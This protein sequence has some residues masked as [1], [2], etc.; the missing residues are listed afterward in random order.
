MKGINCDV[1]VDE[2]GGKYILSTCWIFF[3]ISVFN[4]TLNNG[5]KV[6][7]KDFSQRSTK[8]IY[9]S[10]KL[11]LPFILKEEI[12]KKITLKDMNRYAGRNTSLNAAF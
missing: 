9:R 11:P 5:K 12:S 3:S 4:R 1:Y 8:N 10:V 7:K 6:S 2:M